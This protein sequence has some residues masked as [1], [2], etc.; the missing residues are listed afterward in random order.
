MSDILSLAFAVAFFFISGRALLWLLD[1]DGGLGAGPFVRLAMSFML[2]LGGISLQM[3][4]YSLAH[5][6]FGVAGIAAPWAA[7]SALPLLKK[8]KNPVFSGAGF[9]RGAGI[10]GIVS[11]AIMF[12]QAAYA[13]IYGAIPPITAWDA[14]QTWFFKA[15]VFFRDRAVVSAFF[16]TPFVHPDYPLLTP[17]SAAWVY[18][19]L[20]HVNDALVRVIYPIQYASLLLVFYYLV[21]RISTVR[22]AL[23]S[24]ALL[25]MTPIL[26]VHGAGLP[27]RMGELY[28]GDFVGYADLALSVYFL[29]AAG[30][31][32][33][34]CVEGQERQLVLAA[35]FLGLGAWTKDEGTVF[36]AVGSLVAV[37]EAMRRP[38]AGWKRLLLFFGA[39]F[40]VAGPWTAYKIWHHIPGEYSRTMSLA[41]FMANIGR[42]PRI[43]KF[44]GFIMFGKVSLNSLTWYAYAASVMAGFKRAFKRPLIYLNVFVLAQLSAYVFIFTITHLDLEF[45]LR[46]SVDRLV[47]QLTPVAMLAVA[48]GLSG[49][50]RTEEA[51][52]NL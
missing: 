37:I 42:L 16:D 25:S 2:G 41:A 40:A 15:N 20:G 52:K 27:V 45:H 33:L 6:P 14:F 47:L 43:L 4:F 39:L 24:S 30:F 18:T 31:F 7:L 11:L 51:G 32:H 21:K 36:A 23:V 17:L 12:S 8:W 44:I 46:T 13:F 34:Y 1:R 26:M 3:F 29:A 38:G 35:V 49:L 28:T 10:T 50:L 22:A 9:L 5:V 48:V 19:C